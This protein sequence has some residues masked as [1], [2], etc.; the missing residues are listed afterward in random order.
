[1]NCLVKNDEYFIKYISYECERIDKFKAIESKCKNDDQK[2]KC[3]T[4]ISYLYKNIIYCMCSLNKQKNEFK[5]ELDGYYLYT[6]KIL[7]KLLESEKIDYLAIKYIFDNS[8]E[9]NYENLI[10]QLN[11]MKDFKIYNELFKYASSNNCENEIKVFMNEKW[12]DLCSDFSWYESHKNN[13][14]TYVGYFSFVASAI[15]KHNKIDSKNIKYIIK[16]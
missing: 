6:E 8:S 7:D 1:M 2:Q 4:T 13:N 3:Y 11:L 10:K 14:D 5:K 12:Y 16:F 9:A 15:I